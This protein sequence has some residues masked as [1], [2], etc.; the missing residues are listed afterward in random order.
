[1]IGCSVP[2]SSV[3]GASVI[4]STSKRPP[5]P[6]RPAAWRGVAPGTEATRHVINA[7]SLAHARPGLHLINVSRGSLVEQTG[8]YV[9]A[10]STPPRGVQTKLEFR[11]APASVVP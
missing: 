1:M 5:G 10:S 2:T 7:A 4:S 11:V 6:I 8:G 3:E 9:Y